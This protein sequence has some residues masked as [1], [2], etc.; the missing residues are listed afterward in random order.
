[1]FTLWEEKENRDMEE[2]EWGKEQ[3]QTQYRYDMP[4][5]QKNDRP[6]QNGMAVKITKC[7]AIALVF[8]IVAGGSFQGVRYFFDWA[9][10]EETQE[11]IQP[12]RPAASLNR[13]QTPDTETAAQALSVSGGLTDVSFIAD[14]VMPAIVAIT[15]MSEV[16][17]RTWFGQ[18]RNFE[19]ESAGSGIIVSQ[20]EDYLYIATNNHVVADA[21]NLTVQ[22]C[23]DSTVSAY[24]KGTDVSNDLA[25]VE[26]KLADIE[27]DTLNHIKVAT[28]GS[29]GNLRVGEAAVA[30]GNALGYGQSVTTGIISAVDREVSV[31]DETTGAVTINELIQT[32]AAINPGNSGGALL[33]MR[34]EVIGINTIKYSDTKVEGMGY[35]IP[36]D[37]ASLIIEKLMNRE[38]VSESQTAYLGVSGVDVSDSVSNSYHM[39]EGV[40]VYRVVE[41]SPADIAGIT[42]GDIITEFDGSKV[43]SR[44]ELEDQMQYYKAGTQV[45]IIV[46]RISNENNGTY[47]EQEITV[48]L[49]RKN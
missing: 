29:S 5:E 46:Q 12:E 9:L 34:G 43:S 1:V 40:Y 32:D 16:T 4:D 20:D 23:D 48:T 2:N 17:Y 15:N 10:E 27:A 44:Q 14:N 30:I 7:A 21:V 38:L 31:E 42:Q 41:G 45:A 22:F 47:R 6:V 39:P 26:I 35:A 36:I 19:S 33:N 3:E 49:G 13:A 37:T 28:I 18:E 8:G 11:S 24:V 25:V